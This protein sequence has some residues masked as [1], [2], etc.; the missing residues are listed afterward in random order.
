MLNVP[1]YAVQFDK[2]VDK[3][4]QGGVSAFPFMYTFVNKND[5]LWEQTKDPTSLAGDL[6]DLGAVIPA[7]GNREVYVRLDSDFMFKLLYVRY[8]VYKRRP[9]GSPFGPEV[10]VW[11]QDTPAFF[12]ETANDLAL[13]QPLLDDIRVNLSVVHNGRYLYGTTNPFSQNYGQ[14]LLVIPVQVSAIQGWENGWGQVRCPYLLPAGGALRFD[15]Y[16]GLSLPV[17]VGAVVY[18]LKVRV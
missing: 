12:L 15:I 18:G 5:D 7:L 1:R 6:S 8:F 11:H 16:N 14:N 9:F 17:V 3:G 13:Y 10:F 4:F 2:P